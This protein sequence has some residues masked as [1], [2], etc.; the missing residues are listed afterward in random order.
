M[1]P[2][3]LSL[4]V[5]LTLSEGVER[6]QQ[7]PIPPLGDTTKSPPVERALQHIDPAIHDFDFTTHTIMRQNFGVLF[8]KQPRTLLN[9]ISKFR[10]YFKVERVQLPDF[11][12]IKQTLRNCR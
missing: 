12:A 2:I 7:D 3:V 11:P 8:H 10:L 9:G 6:S 1:F 4:M 5:L